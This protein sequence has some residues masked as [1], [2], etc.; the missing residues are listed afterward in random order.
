MGVQVCIALVAAR[1]VTVVLLGKLR[2]GWL[3]GA[4][5][6]TQHQEQGGLL[7]VWPSPSCLLGN[8][9]LCWSGGTLS[10]SWVSALILDGV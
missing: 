1:L 9:N 2:K 6:Q 3:D 7:R 10:S 4:T 8:T 5:T